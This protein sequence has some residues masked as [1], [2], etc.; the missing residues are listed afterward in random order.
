MNNNQPIVL[1]LITAIEIC[2]RQVNTMTRITGRALLMTELQERIDRCVED[3]KLLYKEV[4]EDSKFIVEDAI[5][6]LLY[7]STNQAFQDYIKREEHSNLVH[8]TI[9]KDPFLLNTLH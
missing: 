8:S 1:E 9:N 5:D 7:I 2:C 6:G 3:F 4:P